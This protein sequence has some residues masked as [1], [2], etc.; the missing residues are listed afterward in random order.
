M[1]LLV[2]VVVLVTERFVKAEKL[3]RAVI[4]IIIVCSFCLGC[5]R[6]RVSCITTA[7][8]FMLFRPLP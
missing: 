5:A 4:F 7:I 8:A 6:F 2:A 1:H 3:I